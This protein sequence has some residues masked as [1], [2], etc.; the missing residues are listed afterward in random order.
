M[1]ASLIA[2]VL[3]FE[4]GTMEEGDIPVFFQQ[5]IDSGM[6]WKLQGFYGRYA[7][8]LIAMGICDPP[9][10]SAATKNP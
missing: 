10:D 7:S 1:E 5:L 6:A 3:A 9:Q 4:D 8:E 2:H